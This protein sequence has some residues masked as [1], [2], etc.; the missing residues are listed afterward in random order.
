MESRRSSCGNPRARKA[1]AQ[2]S[3]LGCAS[4]KVK[5]SQSASEF[6]VECPLH[7][8]QD[9]EARTQL[10]TRSFEGSEANILPFTADLRYVITAKPPP[11]A[12][13][14]ISL[15][16]PRQDLVDGRAANA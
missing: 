11:A 2:T 4:P 9:A 1:A 3:Q 6:R 8:A 5:N 13:L 14:L 15:L 7:Y 10:Q 16:H 12:G